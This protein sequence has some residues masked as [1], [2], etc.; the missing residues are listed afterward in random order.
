MRLGSLI[1]FLVIAGSLWPSMATA[2]PRAR[3]DGEL[4]ESLGE[5]IRDA[6]GEVDEAP[7]N[8]FQAR[9]RARDAAASALAVL[10]S[11]GYYG[12]EV[13]DDVEGDSPPVPVIS[14]VPGTRF[15]ISNPEIE[16]IAPE[17]DHATLA[18]AEAALNLAP[19]QPGRAVD[20]LAAEGRV[21]ARLSEL[22]YPD[23]SAGQRRV[24][25]D[26]AASSL[27]PTFRI[28][29][30][31]AVRLNGV[32]LQ[33]EGR[34]NRAWV[35]SL[36]PWEPGDRYTP[37]A[38][39]ELERRLLETTV[40]DSVSIAL[41]SPE[42]TTPDGLR[43]V[44]VT[45]SD[46]PRRVLEAGAGYSTAEG[47]GVDALW[48][49]RNRFGRAD[50]LT[51]DVRLAEINSRIGVE[52]SLPHWR[53]PGRTLAMSAYVLDE[54]TRAYDRR[55]GGARVEVH[56]RIGDTS[57]VSGSAAVEAG[58]YG[59]LD[60]NNLVLPLTPIE[61]N[62]VI[63]TF[64]AIGLI[65]ST[66]NPLDPSRGWRFSAD[67]QPTLVTGD[68]SF[69]FLRATSQL[70]VYRPLDESEKTIVAGRIRVGSITGASGNDIPSDRRFYSGGGGSLRGFDYQG[71]G[72]QFQDGTPVGGASLFE[73]S[74]EIR[75]RN[76]WHELGAAVFVDAGSI[77]TTS[78][79]DFSDI[80]YS[81]GA[82]V[83]YD[84]PFGP[85]RADI[86]VPLDRRDTDP[87]FQVYISIGQ[88]F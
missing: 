85:I 65:D 76:I 83:R 46:Q 24:I 67:V 42:A 43:P 12:A 49:W 64:G 30:G 27:Q 3:V 53:Q 51:F 84:L 13:Q 50:T 37:E 59:E 79:P 68:G 57:F 32:L 35:E 5:R 21:V 10:R 81:V 18:Q 74:I 60:V 47:V 55:V 75:R 11:E 20:V 82:G 8:R 22:G 7:A 16:W 15:E 4:P 52:L 29:A 25:V 78:A 40:Y 80:R 61:R 39:A 66:D 14:I 41:A 63:A 17:P 56:Q 28:L 58:S 88:A 71:V 73:T 69:A 72:P 36:A 38:V 33:T 45:L 44:V 9:R 62:L 48:T 77:G 1:P 87:E 31:D 2:E 6:V 23:A 54:D 26:H 34:T 70:S 86:A 19:G